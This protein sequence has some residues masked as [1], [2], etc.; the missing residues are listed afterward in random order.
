MILRD[1]FLQKHCVFS[2][3]IFPPKTT[4]SIQT[5]TDTLAKLRDLRPDYIS[6]TYGAGGSDNTRRTLAL[7]RMVKENGVEPLAH[8]TC[9]G[10][11]EEDLLPVLAEMKELG[12]AN[13]LA[14]RGDSREG[15]AP[16]RT[17]R[18]AA[19]LVRFLR[20][21]PFF[22]VAAACY[23]EGHVECE[24]FEAD[25]GHLKQKVEAGVDFLNTQLF[26]DNED[27]FRFRDR[28]AKEGVTVPVA[29]GIMPLV[30]MGNVSRV[31][32]MAGV[33]IPAK[34]SRMLAKYADD[35]AA[36]K[37]AGIAYATDQIS[38]LIAGGVRGIHLYIM[39]N[40]EVARRISAN[41]GE[42]LRHANADPASP[43]GQEVL[44]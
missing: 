40:A 32:A 14:L 17:F 28:L 3:E 2:F 25:I 4:S 43:G 11:E 22:H 15:V 36:L 13:V 31:I 12:I 9:M 44:P 26:F 27:F 5:V 29:A 18:Y 35:E 33:K 1:L 19:D 39:N 10:C 20:R 24:S 6:I 34:L 21:D 7:C 8:L 30:K 37:E 41:V 16:S 23:P 42:M 38:D